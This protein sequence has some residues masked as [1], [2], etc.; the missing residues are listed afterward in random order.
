MA[1]LLGLGRRHL[2]ELGLGA[3]VG[4]HPVQ[5]LELGAQPPHFAR[6]G[7]DRLDRRIILGQA[8]ELV[9]RTGR[10]APSPRQA[11]ACRASIDAIRS[12]EIW[13]TG[14][15]SRQL[16]ERHAALLAASE[17]LELRRRRC[18]SSSS[19]MISAK[20]APA[21]LARLSRFFM[22]PR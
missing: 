3:R 13:V 4:H 12:D 5:H 15:R 14:D 7:G 10:R 18:S 6:R 8:N 22:L 9:G 17:I 16:I 19:P 2:L 1:D 21:S 11:R 20:A